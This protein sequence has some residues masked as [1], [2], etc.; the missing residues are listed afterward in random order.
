MGFTV[1]SLKVEKDEQRHENWKNAC[2][3][4]CLLFFIVTTA[5]GHSLL[6]LGAD[7]NNV[8]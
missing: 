1:E 5:D 8:V 4:T 6:A 3:L 7:A 2:L